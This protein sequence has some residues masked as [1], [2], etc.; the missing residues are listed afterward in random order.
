M[1]NDQVSKMKQRIKI[2]LTRINAHRTANTYFI[3]YPKTGN[4]WI[5]FMLSKYMQLFCNMPEMPLFDKFDIIGRCL[6]TCTGHSI[7]FTHDP[8]I[9]SNQTSSDLNFNNVIKPY[10]RKKVV[11]IV[12]HPL[13]VQA[14]FLFHKMFQVPYGEHTHDSF[15]GHLKDFLEH[16]VF[17]L[18]KLFAFY[19]IWA[20]AGNK[21]D[22]FYVLRYEDMRTDPVAKFKELLEFLDVKVIDH[23]VNE[24]VNYASFDNMKQMEK[25][26]NML[27]DSGFKVFNT[28]DK[29]N[30]DAYHV[31]RGKVGGYEDYL[32]EQEV[33]KYVEI[34]AK[35][36]HPIYGYHKG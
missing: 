6:K 34:I 3:C 9:W 21:V 15:D 1:E 12:R 36:L 20:D 30:P 23:M 8:L 32:T 26:S 13:D 35:N 28:G 4:T 2:Y 24:A 7:L 22:S 31:R 16:P 25:K 10:I 11:L 29:N 33:L 17:G 5:R 14:S 27:Y 18:E 19:N